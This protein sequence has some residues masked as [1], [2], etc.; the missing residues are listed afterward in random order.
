[1]HAGILVFYELNL[2]YRRGRRHTGG[3]HNREG[4]VEV[5]TG[6]GKTIFALACIRE[7]KP[8]TTLVVVPT[9]ALLDQW[10]E[11]SASF[12]GLRLDDINIVSGKQRVRSG[13]INIAVLNTASKLQEAGRA[14]PCFLI[15][16][17]CHKAASQQFRTALDIPKLAALGL[18]AT[19]D[20]PYDDG[21]E[22]VLTPA[23]GPVIYRYTYREAKRDEVI[24][25]TGPEIE[26][27]KEEESELEGVADVTWSRG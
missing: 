8:E 1:L 5:V 11:E 23:L 9:V 15:V 12:F 6:G 4:I 24:V 17:E 21:L 26:R 25:A 3:S 27:L 20:R 22:Q 16:D 18:S 19:P 2:R 7:I 13:T 10:W 14:R